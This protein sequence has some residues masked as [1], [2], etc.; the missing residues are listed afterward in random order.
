MGGTSLVATSLR[1]RVQAERE[2]REGDQVKCPHCGGTVAVALRAAEPKK[3]PAAAE[4]EPRPSPAQTPKEKRLARIAK[5]RANP[6]LL[7]PERDE[8]NPLA[9]P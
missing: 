8:R 9:T 6:N 3:E 2:K 5:R 7:W 4:P 1:Y